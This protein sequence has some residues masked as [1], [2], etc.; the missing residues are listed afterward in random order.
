MRWILGWIIRVFL[1]Q[2]IIQSCIYEFIHL[3]WSIF[4]TR[5]INKRERMK[6]IKKILTCSCPGGLGKSKPAI[7]NYTNPI[8]ERRIQIMESREL[9]QDQLDGIFAQYRN[10]KWVQLSEIEAYEPEKE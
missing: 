1:G 7:E 9:N 5:Q 3:L 10:G 2:S 4:H 6:E 8:Q